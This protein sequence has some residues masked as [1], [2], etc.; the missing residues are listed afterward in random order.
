MPLS[1]DAKALGMTLAEGALKAIKNADELFD[2][3]RL[4]PRK[5]VARAKLSFHGDAFG[6]P[7]P[8]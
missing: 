6:K 4:F 7:Q 8:R 5:R 1:E 2:E 3:A